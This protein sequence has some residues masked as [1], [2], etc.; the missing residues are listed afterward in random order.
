MKRDIKP[1]HYGR[2]PQP[3][4]VNPHAVRASAL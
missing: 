3:G 2:S 1:V 4:P